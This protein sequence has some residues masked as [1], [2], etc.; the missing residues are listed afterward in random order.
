MADQPLRDHILQ[1]ADEIGGP[2]RLVISAAWRD[3]PADAPLTDVV[4]RVDATVDALARHLA[5]AS[6]V[7]DAAEVEGAC[8]ALRSAV[9]AQADAERVADALSADRIQFLE[10]SLEFHD[11]HGTQPC[12]VCAASTLDDDWVVR[13]RAALAAEEGAASALRVARST[14]HRARQ[15]LTALVRGVQTPPAED[16]GLSAAVQARAAHQR[17]SALP[18]DG[19]DA[20]VGHVTGAL[21]EL[22]ATYAALGRDAAADLDVARQAQTW[23]QS[24]PLPREQT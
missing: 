21:P 1:R 14:A 24:S 12:P 4:G 20:L 17:F 19:D 3:L 11:R 7:P 22:R 2:A 5:A 18:A 16:A 23:L 9:D 6:T 13:T 8:A 15:A 10:T